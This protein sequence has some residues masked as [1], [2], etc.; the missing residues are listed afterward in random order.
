MN[1]APGFSVS[2]LPRLMFALSLALFSAFPYRPALAIDTLKASP[3]FEY[4]F[5]NK[6]ES[7]TDDEGSAITSEMTVP[8]SLRGALK[9]AALYWT[10]VLGPGAAS[11]APA[12]VI[13][14]GKVNYDND[15][16]ISP[17]LETG[18]YGDITRLGA[19]IIHNDKG[20]SSGKALITIGDW[21]SFGGLD[22]YSQDQSIRQ[23]LTNDESFPLGP[24]SMHELGHALGI[25]SSMANE[26]D[27]AGRPI[28]HFGDTLSVWDEHLYNE[29]GD[30]PEPGRMVVGTKALLAAHPDAFF[31]DT[32]ANKLYFRGA[33]VSEAL[34]GA[35]NNQVPINAWEDQGAEGWLA[36]FSHI[37]TRNGMMSH[38]NYRNYGTFM[39]VELALMQDLG[40]KIDRKNFFGYSVYGDGLT[41]DNYAG[42]FARNAAGTAYLQGQYNQTP[43][44][45]GLHIYGT[46]NT[47]TQ[48]GDIL[49]SG[50]N[51]LGIRVDGWSN[52]VIVARGTLVRSDGEEGM[53]LAVTYGKNQSITLRGELTALGPGGKAASFDFGSNA[54]S[55]LF[56]VRGSYIRTSHQAGVWAPVELRDELKGPL[57]ERF[58]V[59]GRLAGA[60][61]AI[62]ISP[63][64]YVREVN[65]LRGTA[66]SGAI[67]SQWNPTSAPGDK[68][69]IQH[70]NPETLITNLNFG[71]AM[72]GAGNA[73]P[74]RADKNF[75]LAYTGNIDGPKSLAI[76]IVG[77]RLHYDGTAKVIS[78]RNAAG[79]TLA[80]NGIFNIS[81]LSGTVL[82]G[83]YANDFNSAGTLA[84]GDAR[85]G[86]MTINL[87]AG[88]NFKSSGALALGFTAAKGHDLLAVNGGA[89]SSAAFSGKLNYLPKEDY[90]ESGSRIG[91]NLNDF[92]RL[93]PGLAVLSTL[94]DAGLLQ[95]SPTVKFSIRNLGAGRA[96][97]SASR[98]PDAYSRFAQSGDAADVG[99]ELYRI[100]AAKPQDQRTQ[101]LLAAVDFSG[102]GEDVGAALSSMLPGMFNTAARASIDSQRLFSALLLGRVLPHDFTRN[103]DTLLSGNPP[104]APAAGEENAAERARARDSGLY[105]FITPLGGGGAQSRRDDVT[106]YDFWQ[107]GL[108]AGLEKRNMEYLI[109][110]H[111]A[112]GYLNLD[113]SGLRGALEG[114]S[115]YLGAHGRFSPAAWEG[116]YL[117]GQ[118]RLGLDFYDQER[119]VRIGKES[120]LSKSDWTGFNAT[121]MLGGGYDFVFDD[122]CLG[123]LALMDYTLSARPS[124]KEHGGLAPLDVSDETYNSL[125]S[126]LG[127]RG[128]AT[129]GERVTLSAS[130]LWNH[131]FMNSFGESSAGFVGWGASAFSVKTDI[132]GRDSLSA[133]LGIKA[134]IAEHTS[135]SLDG[136]GEFF[137]SGYNAGWG[138]LTLAWEF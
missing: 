75:A 90:F 89:G 41:V 84:P 86:K 1:P 52:R 62:Y 110:A 100:A 18:P 40:Y 93:S 13:V 94:T 135:L 74:G 23:V 138:G 97:A 104:V 73:I 71:N 113:E 88:G 106:G 92:L 44:G 66:L 127:L 120:G 15:S 76:N 45:V 118:A 50:F 3:L 5:Y 101:D 108:V 61:S 10:R 99:R 131:E 119:E 28:D 132:P 133:T 46:G 19:W 103:G 136:G 42:Y 20:D 109:G 105:G 14:I 33:H 27:P 34:K 68:Y 51:S 17:L 102:T 32:S 26:G 77:G 91:L 81:A 12:P 47:V 70:A 57:I 56:E 134:K 67:I 96:Q 124:V 121:T 79:A 4:S 55:D 39:E 49:T 129:L 38:Q 30:Q 29:F 25:L 6:G 58:D 11:D 114:A 63:N 65:F 130:A 112:A 54:M 83:K 69:Y 123:P 115:L 128:E 95:T 60:G 16:A 82:N 22:F 122:F 137:R 98:A 2:R 107:S 43:L 36:E 48:Y 116:A 72:N 126:G 31:V 59:S 125:R 78:V 35:M 111:L 87:G 85:P 8:L 7:F 24:V 53:G 64:A 21:P 9:N 117:F 37:E 80:G